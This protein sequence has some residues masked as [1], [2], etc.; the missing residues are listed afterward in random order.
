MTDNAKA[1]QLKTMLAGGNS[2]EE[3]CELLEIDV[4]AART[5]LDGSLSGEMSCDE[6]IKKEKPE[7][8]RILAAIAKDE[9]IE[10]VSARVAAA[11]VFV[12][13]KGQGPELDV[14]KLSEYYQKMKGAV[15]M[16]EKEHNRLAGM[17]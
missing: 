4:D 15:K 17:N 14:D 8:L 10:N 11:K 9:S 1:I 13:G 16:Q 7:M 5:F 2:L 6:I 3:A 12:E